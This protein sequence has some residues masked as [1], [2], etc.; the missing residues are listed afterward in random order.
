MRL[1]K[2]CVDKAETPSSGQSF[3]RD[4]QLKGFALRVTSTGAKSFIVETRINGKVRRKTLGRYGRLTAE[5]ARNEAKK[6]LGNVA[7]GGDP[8][9][10]AKVHRARKVTLADVLEEYLATRK[11]LKPRTVQDYHQAL[12]EVCPD[13]LDKPL[14]NINKDAVARRHAEHGERS[15]S[16]ANAAMRV[17]RA[18]FNFAQA[19]YEDA[20][21]HSL[22]PDNAV[23]RLS[24]TRAWYRVGRRQSYIRPHELPSW[25]AAVQ[26]LRKSHC[27]HE[28][29][30]ADLLF[31]LLLTGLR[32]NEG[33][34]LAWS[35]VDL[36]ARTLTQRETKNGEPLTLPLAT[37]LYELL[38]ERHAQAT[39]PYV[40]P[41]RAQDRPMVEPRGPMGWVSSE[42]GVD[43]TLHDL[44]RTFVTVAEGL[45]ISAYAIKRLVNHS[46]GG[47]VTA[48][49]IVYDIDRLREPMQ[50]IAD[51][52]IDAATEGANT[53]NQ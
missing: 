2:T 30:V 40:F 20:E 38:A 21:G 18:V 16:R 35:D 11:G 37:Q 41:G 7:G 45:D 53:V 50:R 48:G 8:I 52:I 34:T 44:R 3:Y 26:S 39:T 14:A 28:Q 27:S 36:N 32:R 15:P 5:E 43:F 22:F 46:V 31:M 9:T 12:S 17:L 51:R 47:D 42:S 29:N 6:F 13:W 49:Y 4:D 33:M 19:R 25:Y 24:Q 1:T 10:A 23:A